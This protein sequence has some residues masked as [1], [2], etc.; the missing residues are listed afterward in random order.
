LKVSQG[1]FGCETELRGPIRCGSYKTDLE[2]LYVPQDMFVR[3][4]EW[5]IRVAL[6]VN[7]IDEPGSAHVAGWGSPL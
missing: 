7:A 3:N 2:L 1:G 5:R 4:Q 6:E